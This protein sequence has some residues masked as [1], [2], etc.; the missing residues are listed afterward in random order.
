MNAP[1]IFSEVLVT[2]VKRAIKRAMYELS[3]AR[4]IVRKD[5]I[6]AEL[7]RLEVDRFSS[8]ETAQISKS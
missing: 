7:W 6:V 1:K 5:D 8:Y 4:S 2:Q 3:N